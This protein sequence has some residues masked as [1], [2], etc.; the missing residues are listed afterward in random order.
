NKLDI[1]IQVGDSASSI[2]SRL[3][4]PVNKDSILE[5][6]TRMYFLKDDICIGVNDKHGVVSFEVISDKD[7]IKE[8]IMSF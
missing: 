1:P 8:R 7:I 3:G 2:V 5:S 6:I 4:N